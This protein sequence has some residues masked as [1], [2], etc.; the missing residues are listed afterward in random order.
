MS[1]EFAKGYQYGNYITNN[2]PYNLPIIRDMERFSINNFHQKI[3][4]TGD[5]KLTAGYDKGVED[6]TLALKNKPAQ[7]EKMTIQ[8]LLQKLA[9]PQPVAN[10]EVDT[11]MQQAAMAQAA[12][13]M[14]A[15]KRQGAKGSDFQPEV[16]NENRMPNPDINRYMELRNIAYPNQPQ[17]DPVSLPIDIDGASAG[18]PMSQE[19]LNIL[20][21]KLE[22]MR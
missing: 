10:M 19:A 6:M 4:F 22:R 18:T 17:E 2:F 14:E 16:M 11:S 13:E 15:L 21:Q 8:A 1:D 5:P 12:N 3:P 20:L 7:G 9:A